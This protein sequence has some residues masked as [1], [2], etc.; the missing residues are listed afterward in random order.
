MNLMPCPFCGHSF[1]ALV[2]GRVICLNCKAS[3]V[4][5]IWNARVILACEPVPDYG[6]LSNY[7]SCDQGGP[8]TNDAENGFMQNGNESVDPEKSG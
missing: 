1:A 7:I 6:S 8:S 4:V 2:A 3:A 5:D